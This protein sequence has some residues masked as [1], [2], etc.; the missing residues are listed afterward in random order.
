MNISGSG[1]FVS[2]FT[3]VFTRVLLISLLSAGLLSSPAL[4]ADKNKKDPKFRWAFGAI[5]G[6]SY[7]VEPLTGTTVLKS[8]DKLKV[9]IEPRRKCFVYLIHHNAQGELVMLFPYDLKQFE[10]D[11]KVNRRYYVPKDTAWFQL[12]NRTGRET[13]YLMAS[14]HRLLDVEYL[15]NR[16]VEAEPGRRSELAIQMVSEIN[17]L[18][19]QVHA[20]LEPPEILALDNQVRRGFERATGADPTDIAGLANDIW[21]AN[22][23]SDIIVIEH[24]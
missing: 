24:R 6:N 7:K 5:R 12:D 4:G 9:M 21:F 23:Y 17:N 14:D 10:I 22:M 2:M 3:G 15:Y 16:Y 8:G 13:F 19:D 1:L 20:S 11:Y 18:S